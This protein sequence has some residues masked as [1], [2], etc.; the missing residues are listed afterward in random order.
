MAVDFFLYFPDQNNAE[1]AG[2]TLR[3]DGYAV[4]TRLGADNV[5]WLVKASREIGDE[6]LDAAEERMV[7]LAGSLGGEFDGYERPA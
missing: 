3:E 1:Q 4:E 2:I 5:N 6:D 7:E